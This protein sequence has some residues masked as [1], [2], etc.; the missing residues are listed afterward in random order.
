MKTPLNQWH[1]EHGG[2]MVDFGGW[3]MPVQYETG[4]LKEHLAT[5]KCAGLFDI[6]HMGRFRIKGK[7]RT[8]FLQHVLSNNCEALEPWQAQYT[9]VPNET[10]GLIDDA[11]LY[12]FGED[13]YLL[14]VN[15][16][17][18]EACRTH[19][20]KQAKSFSDLTLEDNTS[21]LAMIALQG[22]V[23]KQVLESLV[24]SGSL[25]KPF[26]N[27]LGEITICGTPTLVTRT[28]YT[29]E[30]LGFELF[31]PA[32]KAETIWSALLNAG[33]DLGVAPIGLGARD[34][35][36]LEAG[37]PLYGHEFGMDPD[38]KE[39]PAFAFP[40]T[41][42]SVSFSDR[43]GDF[44]GRKPL[45]AQFTA[46][47]ALINGTYEPND[48]LPRRILPMAVL[49][50]GMIRAGDEVFLGEKKVGVVT[51]GTAAPFWKFEGE[52]ATMRITD[53]SQTRSIA[54]AY[55]DASLDPGQELEVVVRNRRLKT[56]LVRFHGRAEAPPF[57]RALPVNWQ[58]PTHSGLKGSAIEKAELL[59]KKSIENHEWRQQRCINMIPSE[60][61]PSK[62]VRLLQV[63][64][65]VGRYAEHKAFLAAF[66]HEVFYYQGTD[67][68]SWA[69]EKLSVEMSSYLGCPLVEARAISGQMANM[70]V[71]SAMLDYKNRTDRKSEAGRIRL[72]M[73]NH[74]ASGGHL[75]AQPMGA[76]RDYLAKDPVSE[77]WAVIN[78]PVCADNPYRMDLPE[79]LK[80]LD[81][82]NP[83]LIIFGKSMVLHPEPVKEIAAALKG[84]K[85]KPV[86]MYDMAHVLG[87][88]GPHFQEPFKDGADIVTG[89]THKTFF[90]TQ[91][92]IVG[93]NFKE[94]T[95]EYDLWK[96]IQQRAFPGMVSN[97]HL[98]TVLGLLLATIEMNT[99]KD[100]YQRQV[101]ANAKA[102]AVSLKDAGLDVAGDP[103]VDYTETHQVI[104]KVG[105]SRGCDI[106]RNLET[107]N[108]VVNY[109]A[110]PSDEGFSA[111]S[112]L[113]L[114]VSEMT[115]FG[116]KE[117]DF[118]ALAP[119][120]ADAVNGTPGVGDKI[121][122]F[123]ARFLD[124][125]FCFD[126][127][128]KD[129]GSKLSATLNC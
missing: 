89:S 33:K 62:L 125:Q 119:L 42:V 9:Q 91:R 110:T 63:S 38:G 104:V 27:S 123:R 12:R 37:M 122:E 56:Q 74:I 53:E 7:D 114:G 35:L 124:M 79:T 90:G 128:L 22:P 23:S 66:D 106:A 78:F 43:K 82:Q 48:A 40:L 71:F 64:D 99:F 44:I 46:A 86:I 21:A 103:A 60:M 8:A 14:V 55:V 75:S 24:E 50:K 11:Y 77:R 105:Y 6:S 129:L 116:M 121:A 109:Q 51:S 29:G 59:L 70:T 117:D 2:K 58:S 54:L 34:T 47:K 118:R 17:N 83:E 101:I 80:L 39:I 102:L 113:R 32:D 95:A 1:H 61:T 96:A 65:P 120:F 52:G 20:E 93:G 16:S 115:R 94:D 10:G 126:S 18:T 49:D 100:E 81:K 88:I 25:P 28:G 31:I 5:R 69:E 108:I 57:F 92:G 85:N 127:E 68:I 15:A 41:R 67:F 19:F 97:H 76:L 73:N 4:I 84:R 26:R 111:A 72:V 87:L 36:R 30:P 98:G 45:E 13:D 112:A 107:S 3:D